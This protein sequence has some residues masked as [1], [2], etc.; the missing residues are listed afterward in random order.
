MIVVRESRREAHGTLTLTPPIH[1]EMTFWPGAK[2][3]TIEPKLEKDAR[4]SAIVLAPTVI[5]DG[6]RAGENELASAL[7]LPAATVTWMPWAVSWEEG[8]ISSGSGERGPAS[9]GTYRSDGVVKGLRSTTTQAH[10]S[11]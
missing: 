5:A 7:L 1:A 11:N 2:M 6:A 3:S 4:A 9:G 8:A 10:R